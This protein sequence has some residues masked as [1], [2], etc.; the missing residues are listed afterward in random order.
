VEVDRSLI[1]NVPYGQWI[2][3]CKNPDEVALTFD[4]GPL[5]YT[6]SIAAQLDAAGF[7]STFFIVGFFGY[8]KIYDQDTRYPELIRSLY[9]GGHQIA[10]HTWTHFNM[11]KIGSKARTRQMLNNEK[12]IAQVL[13][14][15][16]TYMRPPFG[17][18]SSECLAEMKQ[19]GYH[20]VH[21]DI[22]TKDF[23]YDTKE[24]YHKAIKRF[25][26]D[27]EDGGTIALTHDTKFFTADKLVP[28]MLAKL[29]ERGLKGVTIGKCLGDPTENW[30]R[31][32]LSSKLS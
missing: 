16:P 13:G 28:H 22:D 14:A 7:K 24:Q 32:V 21:W 31:P 4:D 6:R 3:S 8:R 30:Y 11:N 17:L 15:V 29:K 12:A 10:S 25:D 26:E 9:D 27:L 18:C 2:H 1:G 20:V 23:E 5:E 19:L